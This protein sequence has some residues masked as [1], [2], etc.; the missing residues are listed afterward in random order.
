MAS[1]RTGRLE[2]RLGRP[3]RPQRTVHA[4]AWPPVPNSLSDPGDLAH[5]PDA[6]L[7]GQ[8][9]IF[10]SKFFAR[11][12]DELLVSPMP[13]WLMISGFVSGGVIR[14]VFVGAIVL[15]V[16]IFFT[17]SALSPLPISLII[18]L[19]AILTSVVFALAGSINGVYAKSIDAINI[20]P[21]F[22]LQPLTYLGGI[23]YSV[24]TLPQWAQYITYVNPHLLPHQRIPL[25]LPRFRRHLHLDL[26]RRPFRAH[27][28][29][30]RAS[31]CISSARDW[32]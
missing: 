13:P 3:A 27:R 31:I 6:L 2:I 4:L 22:I 17:G 32:A 11:S 12:I 30:H 9:R 15:L 7:V 10:Q 8:R 1:P 23:F 20:V 25:R 5:E 18:L 24:H 26:P 21:T 19:F 28:R 14:G 29:P 16:S